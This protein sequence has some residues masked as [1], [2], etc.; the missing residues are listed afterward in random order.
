MTAL[1]RLRVTTEA[2]TA[3]DAHLGADGLHPKNAAMKARLL[4]APHALCMERAR[5]FTESWQATEGL[6]PSTRAALALRRV[7]ERMSVRIDEDEL[8]VGNRSSRPIA[9]PLAPERGDF[10]FVFEHLFDELVRYGYRCSAEDRALLFDV[11]IPAWRGRTVRE[12]KL[13][14]LR[15]HGLASTLDL[16]PSAFVRRLRAFGLARL[17]RLV[18]RDDEGALALLARLPRLLGAVRAG[19][20]DNLKG[21]GRCTDTQAHIVLGHKNVLAKGFAGIRADAIARRAAHVTDDQRAF[22]DAVVLTCDA[23]RAFADRFVAEAG[24]GARRVAS[25]DPARAAELA[26]IAERCAR[27]PWLPPRTFAEALQAVWF[28][29]NVAIISY[30]AGSGI[31]P[32]RLD[33]L[34]IRYYRAD[35][36]RGTLTRAHALRLLEELIIKLNDNVVIWPNIAGAELNHLGTDI[37]NITV[38][39]VD[40]NGDDAT[41]ELSWLFIEAIENTNLATTAS[42]RVSPNSPRAWVRRVAQMLTTTGAPAFLN[43]ECAIA[44]LVNDGVELADARDYCLVGCVEPA[45]NGDTFGA[46]GGTKV[47]FPSAL[48]MVLHRGRTTFFGN[49]DGPDTGDPRRFSSFDQLLDAF[50]AQLELMVNTAVD[51]TN[52][53]D[54]IWAERFHNP[55]ISCTIDGCIEGARDMTE[56]GA[57]YSFGAVGGAGLGTVV[58]SLVTMRRLIFEQRSLTMG[59]LLDALAV[60]F[61]GHEELRSRLC[62]GPRFGVD[63]LSTDELARLVV[64]RFCAM[65]RRRRTIHGG[66]FKASLISYG[67][68]AY[69]GA[70]EPATPDGRHAGAPLSNSMSPSNG[71]ERR[72]PTAALCSVARIDQTQIGFGNSVNLRLPVG[73]VQSDV[74]PDAVA[75]LVRGYFAQGGFHVQFN[76]VDVATLRAAQERPHDFPDLIVRVSGY[77]AYFA[78]LG[79]QVQDDIIGRLEL[80]P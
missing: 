9:P 32:G 69:E 21:R 51:A 6:H 38:G 22:L 27:V 4:A 58:D 3:E 43:D 7:L 25:E 17:A 45:G 47:Y 34:L 76:A 30:G 20:A 78:R 16:S 62:S 14:A 72:G 23:V 40:R 68:N 65:V 41:N 73:L 11:I 8:L 28:T 60:D 75:A 55:L 56:G 53:R 19:A 52:L 61:R 77:A 10:T 80:T 57:R 37:E 42:F 18:A 29:Q 26:D 71:A 36:A 12:A 15:Q 24:A 50:F 67:L 44:A 5:F 31:T 66:P 48:D 13:A 64:E 59:A 39:G 33:Q 49:R 63:D 54:A 70:L 1:A 79:R 35:R 74:G 46:T 2:R